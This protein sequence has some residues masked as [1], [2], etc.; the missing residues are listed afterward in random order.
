MPTFCR[1]GRFIE[2]CRICGKDLPGQDAGP[3]RAARGS[4][5]SAGRS[6]TRAR[7]PA[8]GAG[9]G[10]RVR[11]ELREQDDGYR[12]GLVP[13]LR[14][15]ADA[16]RLAEEIGLSSGR[17][18]GLATDPPGSYAEAKALSG[19]DIDG[20]TWL[21]FLIAYLCP[22]DGEDPWAGIRLALERLP[23]PGAVSGEDA[24]ADVPLG[25]RTSHDPARGTATLVAYVQWVDRA[26]AG[27]QSLAMT[28]DAEWTPERRFE[29]IFERLALPGLSRPARYD[30]MVVEGRLGL[31]PLAASS[32]QLAGSRGGGE[33][34]TAAAAKRVF[35]I[36]EPLLL[37]RRARDLA[38][39]AGVPIEALDLALW[40]WAAP[41]RATLGFSAQSADA[42]AARRA[43]D[44]LGL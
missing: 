33:D 28:G 36:A 1:H 31:Y 30:L 39:A 35:G 20:A 6:T 3:G 15:S 42:D 18:H 12:S 22:L 8:R 17:L 7:Q 19:S 40:N 9:A 44:A 2:R 16:R 5:S 27:T 32:L 23:A 41:T 4:A 37:E 14:A 34:L 26:G 21:C 10:L 25:P 24:L 11:R 43:T 38:D 29:R 13:G